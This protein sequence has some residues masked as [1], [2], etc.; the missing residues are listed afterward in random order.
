VNIDEGRTGKR[1]VGTILLVLANVLVFA[2]FITFSG[3]ESILTEWGFTPA[4][5]V[6]GARLETLV[7]HM[8]FH[9]DVPHIYFNM[10]FLAGFGYSV[11]KKIGTPRFLFVYLLSGVF[12]ALFYTLLNMGSTVVC[13]GASGAIFALMSAYAVVYSK[14]KSRALFLSRRVRVPAFMIVLVMIFAEFVYLMLGLTPSVANA[15]HI[16]GAIGGVVVLGMLFPART[17]DGVLEIV[18]SVVEPI[19]KVIGGIL[20]VLS[21]SGKSEGEDRESAD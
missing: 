14:K 7:T 8:F 6:Q 19:V 9:V 1:P 13:V 4:F 21:G 18:L 2:N 5:I 20:A 12:A 15:V 11:E 10:C 3:Y 16:G 17:L